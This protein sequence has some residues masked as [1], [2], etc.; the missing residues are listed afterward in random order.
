MRYKILQWYPSLPKTWDA[1]KE[2]IRYAPI[3]GFV[4]YS[5]IYDSYQVR[6]EEVEDN[7][8]FFEKIE[9]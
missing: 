3:V 7:P 2:L 1:G 6:K 5:D 8:E 4:Y 9:K